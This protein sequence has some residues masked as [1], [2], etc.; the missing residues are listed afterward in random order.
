MAEL[1]GFITVERRFGL[2]DNI[3]K[4]YIETR[5]KNKLFV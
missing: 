5:T 3:H 1:V 4:E 2:I